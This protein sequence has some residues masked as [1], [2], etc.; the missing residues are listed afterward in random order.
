MCHTCAI[1][2]Q[3]I[4]IAQVQFVAQSERS[5]TANFVGNINAKHYLALD[6]LFDAWESNAAC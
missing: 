1:H 4:H 6:A 2:V 3:S 5:G